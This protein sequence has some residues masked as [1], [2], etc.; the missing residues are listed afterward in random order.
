M[1]PQHFINLLAA[2]YPQHEEAIRN[3]GEAYH[4][5]ELASHDTNEND[6]LALVEWIFLCEWD[7]GVEQWF[8][9]V[10]PGF[11]REGNCTCDTY[12]ERFHTC[13]F[14]SEINGNDR[15]CSCCEY[16]TGQ[17]AADI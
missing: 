17:C 10:A 7:C 3:S 11:E 9:E 5:A 14:A 2:K 8:E 16:C 4:A 6:L 1:T 15:L 13:P 12:T